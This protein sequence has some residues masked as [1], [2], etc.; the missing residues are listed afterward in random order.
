MSIDTI[1]IMC[2]IFTAVGTVGAV[3][4]ALWFGYLGYKDKQPKLSASATIGVL[5]PDEK[6]YL[7]LYC[8]NVG[9]QPILVTNFA[10]SPDKSKPLRIMIHP[11]L[12]LKGSST[13]PT[14]ATIGYG[15]NIQQHFDLKFL[16]DEN[17]N[18]LVGK[19]KYKWIE[20]IRLKRSWRI[21]ARTNI[22][23]FEGKLSKSLID[24]ILNIHFCK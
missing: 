17:F 20:K 1:N 3:I 18:N 5:Y 23:E 10:L 8:V 22:Q 9:Y 14:P 19:Y 7:L 6:Y 13:N 21:I 15:E 24:E 12:E 11:S 2:N 4:V 16:K